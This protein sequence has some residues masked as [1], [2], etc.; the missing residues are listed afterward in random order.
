MPDER[1]EKRR[2]RNAKHDKDSP[3]FAVPVEGVYLWQWYQQ[4]SDSLQRVI[5]GVCRP[6]PPSEF[7]AWQSMSRNIVNHVEYDILRKMDKA[8]CDEMNIELKNYNER[9]DEAREKELEVK[10]HK[11]R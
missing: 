8:Y 6:I 1:G 3:E 7:V 10:T 9:L 11:G 2:D 4:I 5:D